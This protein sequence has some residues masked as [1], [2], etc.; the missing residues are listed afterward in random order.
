MKVK[1]NTKIFIRICLVIIAAAIVFLFYK[2]HFK[3]SDVDFINDIDETYTVTVEKEA[4]LIDNS[5]YKRLHLGDEYTTYSLKGENAVKFRDYFSSLKIRKLLKTKVGTKQVE[6]FVYY[7]ITIADAK[8][9]V[10]RITTHGDYIVGMDDYTMLFCKPYGSNWR[11]DLEAMLADAEIVE[12]YIQDS[13][14][15]NQS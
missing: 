5:E 1:D 10:N 15:V 4:T 9:N 3:G 8:G 2:L 14:Y 6:D 13:P 11:D 12:Y 7:R